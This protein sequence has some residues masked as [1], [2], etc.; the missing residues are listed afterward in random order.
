M[1]N[2][3]IM[4]KFTAFFVLS[5]MVSASII[6]L[7]T[8]STSKSLLKNNTQL[9]SV[10]TL[11][12]SKNGFEIYLNSL[13]Q[14]VNL[15]TQKSEIQH[16]EDPNLV[17]ANVKIAE[18]SLEAALKA[19]PGAVRCAYVTAQGRLL[20]ADAYKEGNTTKYKK[21]L[22]E[23]VNS[24]YETWYVDAV[25]NADN[26]SNIAS[27]TDPYLSTTYG[28]KVITVSRAVK[29]DGQVAGVVALDI[30]F[31]D[32]T[33]LFNNIKLLNTGCVYLVNSSG[34]ILVTPP[35]KDLELVGFSMLP[36][37]S[38]LSA[39]ETV[40]LTA[41][42]HNNNYYITSLT[43]PTTGW[44]LIGM[45]NENEITSSLNKLSISTF[46][47]SVLAVIISFILIIPILKSIKK[48][49]N[50]LGHMINQVAE[51]NFTPQP[52]IG[53]HDEFHTLSV[54]IN[55]M[56][57]NISSLIY[58]VDHTAQAVF[59][60]CEELGGIMTHTHD[61]SNN[62][63]VAI[64]EIST[65]TTQQAESLQDINVQVESLAK[66]LEATKRHTLDVKEM[67]TET[68]ALSNNGLTMLH[69]LNEA[70]THSQEI[71]LT[72][73]NFF[74]EMT[75]SIHKISFISD[76]IIGITN[77]TSLLSLNASIEAAR[78]GES[79]KGFAVVAEEIRKLSEASKQSTDQ[80]KAIVDE[81]YHKAEQANT[82]LEESNALQEEQATAISETEN[83]FHNILASVETLIT[84]IYEI[85]HLNSQMIQSKNIVIENMDEIAAISEETASSSQEVT[86][87]SEEVATSMDSLAHQIQQ[88]TSAAEA[89]KQNL[90]YFHLEEQNNLED[91]AA[92]E[93]LAIQ[94]SLDA[95]T[96]IASQEK[97]SA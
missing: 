78:A 27:C 26:D 29:V 59:N 43:E 4:Q 52:I 10:Q 96:N 72:A 58:N 57:T 44:K 85:D 95:Q 21:T 41:T 47:V 90:T 22:K 40:S 24:S 16:L 38:D 73:Y 80:I 63:K 65:G 83:V 39:D 6:G 20:A 89:L 36:F 49:F 34:S 32:F 94:K 54:H 66:Q 86:A 68:Q 87:S 48:K 82:S 53:G 69:T 5:L 74:K 45:L 30:D 76:A 61:V 51:G 84:K 91:L 33:A 62:V 92:Q 2:I 3:S 9:A 81:I 11:Q 88:L 71:S 14:Q 77:Q 37:W 15:L 60:T 23:N 19:L 31:N 1:K 97:H 28:N 7:L 75:E 42:L 50:R 64:T 35:K 8:Y 12:E 13:Y 56:I 18:D 79:G 46:I 25:N 55:D 70:S 93:Y 67:S 17:E